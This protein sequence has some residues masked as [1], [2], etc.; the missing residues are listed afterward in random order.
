[1]IS[2]GFESQNW[3]YEI[4]FQY[5][6]EYQHPKDSLLY[7]FCHLASSSIV[8]GINYDPV[9]S[10]DFAKG[11]GLYDK[12]GMIQAIETDLDHLVILQNAG[13]QIKYI[14]TFYSLFSS[15]DL[16]SQRRVEVNI[17]DVVHD[18]NLKHPNDAVKLALGVYEF[19]VGIDRC[20]DDN[21]CTTWSQSQV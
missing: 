20:S 18:W 11:V 13:F 14:K 2:S 21:T 6:N 10:F 1:L 4:V 9:H 17:V 19:R 5:Y 8:R 3:K 16:E 12:P 15:L 7:L